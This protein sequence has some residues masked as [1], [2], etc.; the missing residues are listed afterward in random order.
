MK[1][2]SAEMGTGL[3]SLEA[4]AAG[5]ERLSVERVAGEFE[6]LLIGQIWK[7]A[8]KPLGVSH[9]LSGGSAGRTYQDLFIDELSRR[10]ALTKGLG[11]AEELRGQLRPSEL[12]PEPA[13]DE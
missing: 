8:M 10:S 3:R 5:G 13:N 4:M 2:S 12:E 11:L 7:Q 9:V 1:I 6:A